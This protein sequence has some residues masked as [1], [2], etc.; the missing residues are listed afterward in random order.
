MPANYFLDTNIMAYAFDERDGR[1]LSIAK[2]HLDYLF[3]NDNYFISL[4]VINEF[5]NIA[6][7]KLAPPMPPNQLSEFIRLIPESR[8]VPLTRELTVIA[9][10]IQQTAILSFWDSMIIATAISGQCKYLLTEDLTDHQQIG[11]VTIMN[12]FRML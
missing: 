6:Q 11:S 12:P 2:E 8:F 3:T 1:K 9:L 10:E 4:Q 7:K 5:C